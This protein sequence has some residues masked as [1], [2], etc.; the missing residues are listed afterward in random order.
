M[1][2]SDLTS[3]LQELCAQPHEQQWLEFKLNSVTNEKIG[4]YISAISNGATLANKPFGYMVW[5]IHD[6]THAIE[7]TKFSFAKAKQGNQ[8]LELWLQTMLQPKVNFEIFEFQVDKKHV[9]LLRIPPSHGEP[10]YFKNQP[11][12]RIGSHTTSLNKYPDLLRIIYNS[13][14]D[15]SAK[16]IKSAGIRDLDPQAILLAREKFKEKSLN[17][18][19]YHQIDKWDDITFLDKARITIDGKITNTAI[20]LLGK[21]ESVHYLLPAVIEITW[22]LRKKHTNILDRP[23]FEHHKCDAAYS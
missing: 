13:R 2:D 1:T 21:E 15:W 18:P 11:Y 16:I 4:E 6:E 7:G 22:K 5:G 17:A 19:Y 12:I 10:V 3:L 14:E 23:C 9:T 20:I 8:Y